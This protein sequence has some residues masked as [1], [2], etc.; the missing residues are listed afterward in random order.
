MAY[1]WQQR[2]APYR[3]VSGGVPAYAASYINGSNSA[4][5]QLAATSAWRAKNKKKSIVWHDDGM[6][7]ASASS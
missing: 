7:T 2:H 4:R 5:Q 6:K 1:Q 3:F